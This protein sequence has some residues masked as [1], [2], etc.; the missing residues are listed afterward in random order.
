MFLKSE[1]EQCYFE[2]PKT[3]SR[4]DV[5]VKVLKR[6]DPRGYFKVQAAQEAHW[7]IYSTKQR[8]TLELTTICG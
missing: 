7:R 8:P 3:E 5:L 1:V 4:Y 6:E 2:Q